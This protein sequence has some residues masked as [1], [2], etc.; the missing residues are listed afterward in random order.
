MKKTIAYSIKFILSLFVFWVISLDALA[1]IRLPRLIGD[2]MV[3][4]RDVDIKIWGWASPGE[5]VMLTFDKIQYQAHTGDSGIWIIE[6][7]PQNAGGPY[8]LLF[9]GK[10][11]VRV[12]NVLFGDVWLCSGQSNM[13]LSMQRASP[14][15][16]EEIQRAN[17]D[18]IRYFKVPYQYDFKE[19]K[20]DLPSGEWLITNPQTVLGFGAVAYFFGSALYERYHVP[21]GLINSSMGGSPIE[22]WMN[23][24]TLRPFDSA[25]HEYEK[26]QNDSLVAAIIKADQKISNAWYNKLNWLDEGKQPNETP[27]FDPSLDDTDWEIMKVPGYWSDTPSAP[28]NGA[29]W[30]RKSFTLPPNYQS[31]KAMLWMGRIVDADETYIN[32]QKVGNTTYQYPPRRYQIPEQVLKEG[33]NNLTVRVISNVGKGGFIPEKPY[34]LF[35]EN[36]T[37]DL[38]GEWKMKLGA[39]MDPL[40]GQTFIRWKPVGLYNGMIH[41]LI[42]TAIKGAIWYQGESNTSRPE[43]YDDL[44]P[45]LIENWRN[46]WINREDFPFIYVQLANFMKSNSE[47]TESKWARL[48]DAQYQ[49]L[50]VHKTAMVV[51]IDIG[52]WNDI[53]PL[54][55]KDVGNRLSLAARKIAYGEEQLVHSGPTLRSFQIYDNR[56]I[57]K[58]DN[59][60]SGLMIRGEELKGFAIAGENRQFQWA[61]AKIINGKI[62]VWNENI[63]NPRYVRYAWADNPD[64]ANLYNREGLPASPFRI[65]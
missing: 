57:L 12:Q 51:T 53:H 18:Q 33:D 1:Q 61:R 19:T 65:E 50:S 16:Q 49:A 31:S 34:Q 60:G 32:G 7:P 39:R 64:Q 15:Y 47:P 22:A 8:E 41:P 5:N 37:I 27:W 46:V 2:G 4:Q 44:F 28:I 54:N 43:L 55:K 40:P 63:P 56:L 52:E 24:E 20:K 36:D 11:D 10:N 59:I 6:L 42:Q 25:F 35:L 13:E 21:I 62:E 58:F 23:E 17:N 38:S 45:A 26:F 14:I 29:V 48:R 3:L 30:F 9:Q